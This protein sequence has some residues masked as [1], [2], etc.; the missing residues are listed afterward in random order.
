MIIITI[1][2]YNEEKTLDPVLKE[3]K[4]VM[5]QT[6]YRYKIL[7]V[8]DG[9]S[10]KTSDVARKAGAVVIK[11][12]HSGLLGTFKR[13]MQECIRLEADIIVH[14]D[15]DGQYNAKD[16][17]KLIKKIE[18]GYDLVLGSR[19][20]QLPKTLSFTK[21]YGNIIFTK[22]LSLLIGVKTTDSTTGFRAFK[23]KVAKIKY[24]SNFTY[25]HEQLIKASWLK[26]KITEIGTKPRKTRES[27]L[28]KNTFQ[29]AIRAWWNI[30]KIYIKR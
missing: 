17:P 9:S 20:Q 19:F 16:V 10:D 15:A 8:D 2:A 3:I 11:K 14:T 12:E 23:Q 22:V 5:D 13:E 26:Y 27:R 21:K 25:T 29:Y 18:E 6:N 30:L 28:F 1:P 24:V 4:S 7:V